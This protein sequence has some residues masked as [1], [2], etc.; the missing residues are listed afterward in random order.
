MIAFG[1]VAAVGSGAY[2]LDFSPVSDFPQ[3]AEE[4]KRLD[5]FLGVAVG[6]D[7]NPSRATSANEEDDVAIEGMAGIV[8]RRGNTRLDYHLSAE[9]RAERYGDLDRVDVEEDQLNGGVHWATRKVGLEFTGRVAHL[10][11]PVDVETLGF[12]LLER[13]E[14]F[15]RPQAGFRSGKAELGVGY[16][17]NS[18]DYEGNLLKDLDH[19]DSALE[20]EFC[21]GEPPK[22][23]Y[24]FHLDSG[25]VD[26][27]MLDPWRPRYDF[28]YRK[29]YVGW[30]STTARESAIELGVGSYEVESDDFQDDDGLYFTARTTRMLKEGSSALE[31]GYTRGPEAAATADFKTASRFLLRYSKRVTMRSRWNLGFRSENSD[32]TNPDLTT[33]A[34]MRVHVV[35]FG[36]EHTLGSPEAW[37]GRLHATVGYES[38]DDFDRL[39]ILAGIGMVY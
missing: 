10:A 17:V 6:H 15:Y 38:G 37:H 14:V 35:D 16:R 20:F 30:R 2:G 21:W 18:V 13:T 7:S 11:D 3:P 39:R 36:Y 19:E 23:Q 24:F 4:S 28:D 34:S 32:F 25:S 27:E 12:E 31:I 29:I 33:A 26:Y 8:L 1:L 5:V 9:A 22:G